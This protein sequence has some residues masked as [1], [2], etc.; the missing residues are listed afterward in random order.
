MRIPDDVKK[1]VVFIGIKKGKSP[2]Q[3]PEYLGTGC[4]VSVQSKKLPRSS[5]P[6]VVTAKHVAVELDGKDIYMRMNTKDGKS[7][8]F[9][10]KSEET[11]WWFH[12]K[13][14]ESSDVAIFPLQIGQELA[15]SIDYV[16]IK[17]DMILTDA[18]R[19]R[20]GIGE[21]DDVFTVGLFY[22]HQGESKNHP[23]V[24]MGNIAMMPNEPIKHK[25]FGDME[26]YLIELRSMGGLS[27]APVFVLNP[28]AGK[29]TREGLFKTTWK[30]YLLGLI[31][32]HWERGRNPKK[33]N[34]GIAY[35]APAKRI[36]ETI[37]R[38]ELAE[39]RSA[40]EKIR[41]AEKHQRKRLD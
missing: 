34:V 24:R 13:E 18:E 37:D 27:G 25:K 26:A 35:V 36:L 19:L 11:K 10:I 40:L 38:E 23:I 5:F 2:T 1:C 20:Q 30:V 28:V 14:D 41:I 7:I 31:S 4:I 6:Y 12:P 33:V 21:G 15:D 9:R 17:S 16:A 39:R 29:M 22:H 32:G 3:E 8:V